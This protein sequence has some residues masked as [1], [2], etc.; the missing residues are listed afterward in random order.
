MLGFIVDSG[1]TH[2]ASLS[3]LI[4][5]VR[6]HARVDE[7]PGQLACWPHNASEW[8]DELQQLVDRGFVIRLPRDTEYRFR[9]TQEGLYFL[10][11]NLHPFTRC[12]RSAA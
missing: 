1:Q 11:G 12:H 8:A 7:L 4:H 10:R 9:P 6:P 2:D 5:A 3:E